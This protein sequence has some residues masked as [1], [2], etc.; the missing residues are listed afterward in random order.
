MH[1]LTGAAAIERMHEQLTHLEPGFM[2]PLPRFVCVSLDWLFAG[3]YTRNEKA[4]AEEDS[5]F[6]DED[7]LFTEDE[8][9]E[10]LCSLTMSRSTY[11]RSFCLSTCTDSMQICGHAIDSV[12]V[13]K[14]GAPDPSSN[15]EAGSEPVRVGTGG[16]SVASVRSEAG[17]LHRAALAQV[18]STI[19]LTTSTPHVI[20]LCHSTSQGTDTDDSEG[21]GF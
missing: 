2:V 10:L 1:N 12:N 3:W 11:A 16:A 18:K 14:E 15:R 19:D 9:W 5:V 21:P 20:N 17:K 13:E 6:V 4:I 7:G 8:E